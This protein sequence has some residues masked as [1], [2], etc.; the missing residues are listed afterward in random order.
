MSSGVHMVEVFLFCRVTF[1]SSVVWMSCVHVVGV[2]GCEYV[3]ATAPCLDRRVRTSLCPR[4]IGDSEDVMNDIAV[5][6]T[7][8]P[9]NTMYTKCGW[10]LRELVFFLTILYYSF[11]TIRRS[12]WR[13]YCK[14][15]RNATDVYFL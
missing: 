3:K 13:C 8:L 10:E 7:R 1:S 4:P 15:E 14:G 6:R 5:Y 2:V 11:D 9:Y 12:D